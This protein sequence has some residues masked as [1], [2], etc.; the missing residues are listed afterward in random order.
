MTQKQKGE[1]KM[2]NQPQYEIR[3]WTLFETMDF[4]TRFVSLDEIK[5]LPT[6]KTMLESYVL[7][8]KKRRLS[9]SFL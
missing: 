6:L 7:D 5:D 9:T 8:E 2:K 4:N 3:E 1:I